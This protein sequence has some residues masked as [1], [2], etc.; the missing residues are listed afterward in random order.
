M[1]ASAMRRYHHFQVKQ[2]DDV[3]VLEL[4]DPQLVE[5]LLV[6]ELR[7]E[8]GNFF[9]EQ[10]PLKILVDFSNVR[11]SS[12]AGVNGLLRIRERLKTVGGQLKLCGM[13][14]DV[15]DKFR[16]LNLDGRVFDIYADRSEALAAFGK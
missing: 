13:S 2:Q 10:Q 5:Y 3:T 6:E 7:E 11:W 1:T 14:A 16:M 12:T 8:L 9:E 4:V 15:R